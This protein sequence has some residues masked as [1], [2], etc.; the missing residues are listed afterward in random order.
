MIEKIEKVLAS[1]RTEDWIATIIGLICV[2]MSITFG[3]YMPTIPTTF[4]GIELLNLG[5]MILGLYGSL[6]TCNMAL[7]KSVKGLLPSLLVILA[8]SMAAQWIASL[9]VIKNHTGLEGVFFAVT[10]GLLIS[11]IFGTPKW[12]KSGAQSEFF[13]KI[14][15]VLLGS[16][17]IFPEIMKAGALGM[18]QALVVIL[19]VWGF[20]YW[21]ARK[22]GVDREMSTMLASAV[23]ICGVSAAIATC[24]AIKGDNRKL[25]YVISLVL[26]VAIP[27]MYIMPYAAI[28]LGLSPEVGGAW[29]GGT[30][31][32]TGAV[33]AAGSALGDTAEQYAVIVKSSQNVLLGFAALFISIYWTYKGKNR[34]EK[35]TAGILWERF[36][37][38]VIGFLLASLIFS[39]V[40][41]TEMAHSIGKATKSLQS[42][43]FS[44]AFVC[45]GLET[46]FRDIFNSTFKKPMYAFLVAQVFN[47][48]LT[49]V[50]AYVLF[51][52]FLLDEGI[53][54]LRRW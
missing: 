11:N 34:R 9:D 6:Y 33:V 2:F 36:P 47:I 27:M 8:L 46:R 13:V 10:L 50:V 30:I 38:F 31:D 29:L 23:S 43:L 16:T 39:F 37:K 14:G 41:D 42:S 45:I 35:V 48:L 3:S 24:G 12:L 28:W 25:S 4:G 49:L 51:D 1:I 54:F 26:V 5:V 53:S 52:Y 7:G 32:T 22:M 44:I 21:V 18:V 20:G 40:L 19:C 17:I 15:L